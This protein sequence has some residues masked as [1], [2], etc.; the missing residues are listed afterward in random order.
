MQLGV[1]KRDNF[2]EIDL[3]YGSHKEKNGLEHIIQKHV[4][5]Q[6]DFSSPEQAVEIMNDVI[7]NGNITQHRSD[8]AIFEKDGYKVIVAKVV[9]D[10]KGNEVAVKNW[11]VTAFDNS[12]SS[13]EK[14]SDVN[15]LVTPIDNNGSRA[16]ASS[17]VSP[18]N[19]QK[20]N[21]DENVPTDEGEIKPTQTEGSVLTAEQKKI[22]FILGLRNDYNR[23]SQAKKN[24][25]VGKEL[26]S[27]IINY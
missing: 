2:G 13:K 22:N 21:Q 24:Q 15:T 23:L 16:V 4:Y 8:K 19:I 12:R 3:P 9:R 5:E 6:N 17:N 18:T 1:F 11:V 20:T 25:K 26:R 10:S 27:R 7:T 14:T